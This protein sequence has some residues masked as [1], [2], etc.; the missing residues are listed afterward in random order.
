MEL[1]GKFITVASLAIIEL[2]I[3]I[4]AGTAFNLHP[5]LNFLASGSGAI[6]GALT[7]ILLSSRFRSWLLGRRKGSPKQKGRIYRVWNKY[8]VIG[9]GM[10]A[11]LLTGA[12]F[13]AAI[14]ISLGAPSKRLF[15]WMCTGI[16]VWTVLLTCVSTLGFELFNSACR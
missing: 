14:G 10:L 2:W 11:P 9:L 15:L 6:I 4:P 16:I 12:P 8:G 13:G 1:A 5:V 3:A 7:V